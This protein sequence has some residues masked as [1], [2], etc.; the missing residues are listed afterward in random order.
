MGIDIYVKELSDT[1]FDEKGRPY[2]T[3]T[4]IGNLYDCDIIATKIFDDFDEN[5]TV[6][7]SGWFLRVRHELLEVL[8]DLEDMLQK[9][10]YS[11]FYKINGESDEDFIKRERKRVKDRA[12][13]Y[14]FNV[15]ELEE[16]LKEN[17]IK[18]LSDEEYAELE[19][20]ID[21]YGEIEYEVSTKW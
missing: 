12:K 21:S 7:L 10:E 1:K 11:L 2:R 9:D 4:T 14:K 8:R 17:N 6:V 15:I 19:P 3:A 16:F 20:T 5:Y 18:I 13:E